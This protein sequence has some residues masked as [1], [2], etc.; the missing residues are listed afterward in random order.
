MEKVYDELADRLLR[1]RQDKPSENV[2]LIA[3]AGYPGSGK[4]TT[5]TEVA[6][7]VNSRVSNG[8][9][10]FCV[11]MPMDGY[12][13]Y[14]RELDDMEDPVEAHKR[15]GSPWT[16]NPEKMFRTVEQIKSTGTA[17]VPGFDH[18]VGDPE[19]DA[20]HITANNKIVIIEGLYLLLQDDYWGRIGRLFDEKWFIDCEL[21]EALGRLTKRHMQAWGI[22]KQDAEARIDYNDR[23]N[24]EIVD[25]SKVYADFLVPSL[26][27]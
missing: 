19:E 27:L 1:L 26:P 5:A 10:S 14:R 7:R 4:T 24:A 2:V 16:F 23:K 6:K 17:S 12:H 9:D 22:S 11:V 15:R 21:N 20:I 3:I 25:A 13:L 18:A 8:D